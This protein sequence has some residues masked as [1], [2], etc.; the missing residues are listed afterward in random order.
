M[1]YGKHGAPKVGKNTPR[2]KGDTSRDTDKIPGGRE[3][4]A[5]LLARM[6]AT[7]EAKKADKD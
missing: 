5:A 3:T 1:D 4:K 6:K 7:A 2:F